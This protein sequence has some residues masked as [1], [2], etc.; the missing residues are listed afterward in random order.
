MFLFRREKMAQELSVYRGQVEQ[1]T[2]ELREVESRRVRLTAELATAHK[3]SLLVGGLAAR[4][5][6]SQLEVLDAQSRE[7]RLA[8]ELSDAEGALPRF[9]PRSPRPRPASTRR[10]PA[11]SPRRRP[12]WLPP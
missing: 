5:A 9:A 11:S 12:I 10:A 3:R 7:Q 4:N 1:R 6:A 8:T 2:A